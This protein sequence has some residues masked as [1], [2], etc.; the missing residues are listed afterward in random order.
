MGCRNEQVDAVAWRTVCEETG[1]MLQCQLCP[2]SPTYWRNQPPSEDA[3]LPAS[4]PAARLEWGLSWGVAAD[5]RGGALWRGTQRCVRCGKPTITTSPP[6]ER[7]PHGR[8]IHKL[9][10]ELWMRAHPKQAAAGTLD[11]L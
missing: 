4:E 1:D 6:S 10:A 11:G 8:H 7:Y 5:V 2:A 3:P 9:C